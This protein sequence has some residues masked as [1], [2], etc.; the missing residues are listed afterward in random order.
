LSPSEKRSASP[1]HVAIREF[2]PG[3][4]ACFRKLNEEWITRHFSLEAKDREALA[5][6][7]SSILAPGGRILLAILE[8]QCVGC[9]A[10]LRLPAGEFE[11]AKMAVDPMH[12]GMGIGR[13]LLE[14]AAATARAAGG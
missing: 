1:P 14:A 9:C 4:E 13:K 2:A 10:L 3:D 6:P 5:D 11:V 12:Q 7:R 8:D